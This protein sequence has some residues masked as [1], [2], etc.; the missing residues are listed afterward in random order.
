[1]EMM[2]LDEGGRKSA[3]TTSSPVERIG[4]VTIK[5]DEKEGVRERFEPRG[6]QYSILDETHLFL[7]ILTEILPGQINLPNAEHIPPDSTL[8]RLRSPSGTDRIHVSR[9]RSH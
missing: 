9:T 7:F 6:N 3:I 4:P 1:M 5:Q 8:V 2:G